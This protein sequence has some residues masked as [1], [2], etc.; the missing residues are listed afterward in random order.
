MVLPW[1]FAVFQLGLTDTS[2][3]LSGQDSVEFGYNAAFYIIGGFVI[4]VS[5]SSMHILMSPRVICHIREWPEALPPKI[6]EC[7]I[8]HAKYDS[9]E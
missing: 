5:S 2:G 3:G 8:D 6:L 1:L 9:E 4:W 7:T